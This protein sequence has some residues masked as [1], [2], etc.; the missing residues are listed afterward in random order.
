MRLTVCMFCS[1]LVRRKKELVSRRSLF[2]C[3]SV[4]CEDVEKFSYYVSFFGL[5]TLVVF[6]QDFKDFC[7]SAVREGEGDRERGS[8]M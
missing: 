3:S 1:T 4:K 2:L 5:M 6:G 8:N 7:P